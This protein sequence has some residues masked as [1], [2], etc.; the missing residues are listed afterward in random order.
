MTDEI[1]PASVEANCEGG[2]LHLGEGLLVLVER[3]LDRLAP[4]TVTC[5][6]ASMEAG[7]LTR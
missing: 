3:T 4:G 5:T 1:N 2:D 6:K 7:M